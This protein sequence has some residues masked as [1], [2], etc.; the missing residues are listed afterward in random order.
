MGNFGMKVMLA[1]KDI[2][3]NDP[4]DHVM[5]SK[6]SSVKIV[7]ENYGTITVGSSSNVSGTISHNLGFVPMVIPYIEAIP[8]S[9]E[10]R[11]GCQPISTP[12]VETY[13]S[14]NPSK[15]YVGTANLVFN[16]VNNTGS[17]KNVKYKFYVMGDSGNG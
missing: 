6:Y 1:G 10:W 2:T 14:N 9:G 12:S 15:T 11:M 8:G 13:L 5:S 16:I 7:Q 17:S 4:L 3:S